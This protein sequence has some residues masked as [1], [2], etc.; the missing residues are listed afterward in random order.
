VTVAINETR[1]TFEPSD[2]RCTRC[3]AEVAAEAPFFSAIF[4]EGEAF[5]RRSFCLGC[6]GGGGPEAGV[7][8]AFW[9]TRRPA[10]L[11]P[12][13]R[14]RFDQDLVLE[15]F[16]RLGASLGPEGAPAAS[17]S[18]SASDGAG[19]GAGAETPPPSGGPTVPAPPAAGA[20]REA[21][22]RL[23]LVLSLLLIRRKVLVFGSSGLQ[24][25]REW[26]QLAEKAEPGRTYLV[27]NPPL[28]DAQLEA[29]K[30]S[31]GELLQM[32]L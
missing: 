11:A 24:D 7:A 5:R 32:D 6:W 12:Q 23:R 17:A 2:Y 8:Y 19:D 22:I 29:V 18:A 21:M 10:P 25:G 3:A 30:V 31:L 28:S 20:S 9:R 16:R 4:F 1:F 26:L 13:R 27:E 14:I 15:F